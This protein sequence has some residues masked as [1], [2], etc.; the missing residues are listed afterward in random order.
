VN[1]LDVR[2]LYWRAVAA[3]G[4]NKRVVTVIM[5]ELDTNAPLLFVAVTTTSYAVL[6]VS[7]VK[8]TELAVI[9]VGT[10]VVPFRV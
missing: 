8:L 4:G 2:E 10:T 6:A 7:P 1:P 9:G 3:V 5:G